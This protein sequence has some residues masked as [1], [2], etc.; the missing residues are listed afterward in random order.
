MKCV[1]IVS[2]TWYGKIMKNK[3]QALQ[4]AA[5]NSEFDA[6]SV[7]ARWMSK[8]GISSDEFDSASFISCEMAIQAHLDEMIKELRAELVRDSLNNDDEIDI[9]SVLQNAQKS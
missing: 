1:Q 5:E 4:A 9:C 8:Y 3:L 7:V 2:H 6:R